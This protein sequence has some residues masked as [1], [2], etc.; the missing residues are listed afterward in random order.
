MIALWVYQVMTTIQMKNAM[1]GTQKPR[2][3]SSAD[4]WA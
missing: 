1:T 4:R 3:P 2:M